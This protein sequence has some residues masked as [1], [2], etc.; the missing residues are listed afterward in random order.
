M[1]KDIVFQEAF[2]VVKK[3]T[4][5]SIIPNTDK[6]SDAFGISVEK[7]NDILP[8]D[9][10]Q[11]LMVT[12]SISSATAQLLK[13][14]EDLNQFIVKF[15]FFLKIQQKFE[16]RDPLQT[17]MKAFLSSLEKENNEEE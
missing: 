8:F 5:D 17:I 14:S 6:F 13:E 7:A 15:W 16:E 3:D 12:G 11:E 10:F 2:K 9:R 1:K 4:L